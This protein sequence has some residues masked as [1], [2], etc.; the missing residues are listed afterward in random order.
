MQKLTPFQGHCRA[1]VDGVLGEFGIEALYETH[2]AESAS[3]DTR[4]AFL[5]A[6]FARGEDRYDLYIYADE[7]ALNSGRTWHA[8]ERHNHPDPE[9][10]VAAL[11]EFLRGCLRGEDSAD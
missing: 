4:R 5:R 1:A 8:F 11:V 10:P 2:D 3:S 7:A 9:G 6:Q